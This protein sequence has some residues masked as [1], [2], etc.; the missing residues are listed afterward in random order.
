MAPKDPHEKLF[1]KLDKIYYD[2]ESSGSYGGVQSLLREAKARGLKVGEKLIKSYLSN[3]ASYSLHKSSRKNFTRNP[4]VVGGIDQ[5]WQADLAD[6]QAIAKLNKGYN[7]ILTVIDIFSKYAWA[8]PV[9]NKGSK[10]MLEAFKTLFKKSSP[11]IPQ[12]LQTDAG[13]EFLNK[14]VQTY[15]KSKGIHHFVSSSDK[16]AA[17]VE[18]FNRT[19]KTRIWRFFTAHQTNKYID[20]LEKFMKSY[21]NSFHRSIK[22]KPIDV[23][24][25][26][27]DKI[28]LTLYGKNWE[29]HRKSKIASGAK[30]RISKV[31]GIFEKGYIP[32]WSE[33]HFHVKEKISKGRPVYKLK[34]DLGDDIKGEFYEDELQ[35]ITENRY[36]VDKILRKRKA[37]DGSKEFFIKWKG[38]PAKFNSWI[39]ESDFEDI[40]K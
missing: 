1:K 21:N 22:M 19:L 28:W 13:K 7:Y 17:V 9:K 14:D 29:G 11:R 8:V 37:S 39:K 20:S 6:M 5:Q 40:S 15:L 18:R 4:T 25:K 27:Q 3:Q 32:N 26:D 2:S 16:K 30:V 12:K 33:E 35:P 23:K 38:W 31:K 10:E 36:L 24:S 34:D